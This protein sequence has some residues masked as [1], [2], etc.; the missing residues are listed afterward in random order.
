MMLRALVVFAIEGRAQAFDLIDAAIVDQMLGRGQYLALL[1]VKRGFAV[2][3]QQ[4]GIVGRQAELLAEDLL[5][6][7]AEGRRRVDAQVR[8]E[9]IRTRSRR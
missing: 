3:A 1:E 4:F 8:A 7:L 9:V 5:V 2:A 6:V